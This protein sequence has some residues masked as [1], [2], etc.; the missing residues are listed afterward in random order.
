MRSRQN[1]QMNKNDCGSAVKLS[2]SRHEEDE[3][4]W[5]NKATH[6][7]HKNKK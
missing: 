5:G 4:V 3:R 7:P 2:R 6:K 1:G